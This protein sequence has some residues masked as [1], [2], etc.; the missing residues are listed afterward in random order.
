M[1]TFVLSVVLVLI[2]FFYAL[3]CSS[4]TQNSLYHYRD[5]IILKTNQVLF[6]QVIHYGQDTLILELPSGS[7]VKLLTS[8]IK[9]VVQYIPRPD[10][11]SKLSVLKNP[12]KKHIFAFSHAIGLS[13][14]KSDNGFGQEVGFLYKYNTHKGLV[15]MGGIGWD[16]Y[17]LDESLNYIPLLLGLEIH[18]QVKMK[19]SL[20]LSTLSGYSLPVTMSYNQLHQHEGGLLVNPAIGILFPSGGEMGFFMEIGAKLQKASYVT[21]IRDSGLNTLH[22]RY[23]IR[24]GMVF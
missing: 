13:D 16:N 9:R 3:E 11:P 7:N 10:K 17:L 2:Q 18:F 19:S 8:Q 24:F 14:L 5:K 1:R 15:F 4:Q 22:K 20:Y 21:W 12:D 23:L 6:G